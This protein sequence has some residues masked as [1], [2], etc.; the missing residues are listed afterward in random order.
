MAPARPLP[1]E[2]R[3]VATRAGRRRALQAYGDLA[4]IFKSGQLPRP[5]CTA[6]EIALWLIIELAAAFEQ[7][8]D[9]WPTNWS[10]LRTIPPTANDFN[11]DELREDLFEDHDFLMLYSPDLDGI[12]DPLEHVNAQLRIGPYLQPQ[13]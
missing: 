13:D 5:A 2:S 12:E 8:R 3:T 11:W 4:A 10:E 6:E 9:A 7:D 1:H